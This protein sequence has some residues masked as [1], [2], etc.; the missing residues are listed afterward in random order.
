VSR[1]FWVRLATAVAAL[2]A[3]G[4][5]SYFPATL[6]TVPAGE[7]VRIFV[8]PAGMSE[9]GELPVAAGP[10]LQGTLVRRE[11]DGILLHVPVAS[12]EEGFYRASI[13]Q[14]VRI[15]SREILRMERRQINRFTTGLLVGGVGATAAT[16][17]TFSIRSFTSESRVPVDEDQMRLPLFSLSIR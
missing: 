6:E 1:C 15:P 2:S 10:M 7:N 14:D 17:L 13:G 11:S 16:V 9:V 8:S 5:F 12:R 3:S 4:C